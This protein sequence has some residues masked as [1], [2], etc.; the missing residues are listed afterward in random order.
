MKKTNY[1]VTISDYGNLGNRLQNYAVNKNLSN[2]G[3]VVTAEMKVPSKYWIYW[4]KRVL[5]KLCDNI[6]LL[7]L[8]I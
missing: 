7:N 6:W 5:G 8:I 3:H 2:H 1:I 4:L